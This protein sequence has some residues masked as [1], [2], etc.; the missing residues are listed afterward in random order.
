MARPKKVNQ[1]W[2][3]QPEERTLL[4]Q[5]LIAGDSDNQARQALMNAGYTTDLTRQAIAHYRNL[6]EVKEALN[7]LEAEARQVGLACRARRIAIL[8]EMAL[9]VRQR[10]RELCSRSLP[11]RPANYS[12]TPPSIMA[13]LPDM[14]EVNEVPNETQAPGPA[15]DPEEDAPGRSDLI[16]FKSITTVQGLLE[17]IGKLV[18]APPQRA[19]HAGLP[20]DP[21][22]TPQT[23]TEEPRISAISARAKWNDMMEMM[24]REQEALLMEQQ[25]APPIENAEAVTDA[26]D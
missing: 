14:E 4:I 7:D 20:L 12:D 9:E 19:S 5:H 3:L 1:S 26:D 17:D 2:K 13:D 25:G 10:S 15:P 24:L 11:K 21:R 6:E 22:A 16:Y 8:N 23:P 18:D